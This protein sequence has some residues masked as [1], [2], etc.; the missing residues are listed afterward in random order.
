M[1]RSKRGFTLLEMLIVV[2]I[3]VVL[4]VIAI[5][6]S[7]KALSKTKAAACATNRKTAETMLQSKIILG[8]LNPVDLQDELEK[9]N[10]KCPSNGVYHAK[11]DEETQTVTVECTEHTQTITQS[12]LSEFTQMCQKYTDY[13]SYKSNDKMRQAIYEQLGNKWNTIGFEGNETEY[14]IQPYWNV[15][16]SEMYI[17][18][19]TQ[20]STNGNWYTGYIYNADTA[21]WYHGPAFSFVGKPKCWDDVW[22]TMQSKGWEPVEVEY[23][24]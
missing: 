21:T 1:E 15:D 3:I 6:Q 12:V 17:F 13:A 23:E 22:N 24:K 19:S 10:I 5:P 4:L 20:S 18:A 14:Y 9:L 2:A 11:Y 7:M 8:D 16:S